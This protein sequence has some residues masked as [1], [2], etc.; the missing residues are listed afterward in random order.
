MDERGQQ[1]REKREE[2]RTR[3]EALEGRMD[4]EEHSEHSS[5]VNQRKLIIYQ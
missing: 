5:K 4:N 2:D 1:W 3:D